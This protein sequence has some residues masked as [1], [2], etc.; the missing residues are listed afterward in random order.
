MSW[1]G[2]NFSDFFIELFKISPG[3]DA[4]FIADF[5]EQGNRFN[6]NKVLFDPYSREITHNVY[7][8]ALG[9]LG[10]NDGVLGTGGELVDGVPRR[11]IDTAPYA[12]KG[13]VIAESAAPA[14]KPQL[15]PEQDR[16][17]GRASCRERV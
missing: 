8:D 4:G 7:T 12:P 6:P 10:V 11:R 3:S 9:R 5:D 16:K 15:P 14:D 13:I 2:Y 17:I 1:V